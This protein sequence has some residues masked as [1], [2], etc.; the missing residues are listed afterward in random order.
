MIRQDILG[1]QESD[2]RATQIETST[3]I[4]K[5][6]SLEEI[7]QTKATKIPAFFFPP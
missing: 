5:N 3:V 4:S 1:A 6:T 2:A 7:L